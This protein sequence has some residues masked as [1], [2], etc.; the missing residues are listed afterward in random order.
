MKGT[1]VPFYIL[2]GIVTVGNL[3]HF[4]GYAV[5][6]HFDLVYSRRDVLPPF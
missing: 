6:F 3:A 5:L 1:E 4:V 2:N